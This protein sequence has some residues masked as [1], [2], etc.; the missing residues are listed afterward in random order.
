MGRSFLAGDHASL[1]Y[2]LILTIQ[3]RGNSLSLTTDGK[4]PGE[5][6]FG[7]PASKSTVELPI[8]GKIHDITPPGIM[9]GMPPSHAIVSATWEG[10]TLIV[11]ERSAGFGGI[12]SSKRRYF[13]SEDKAQLI[14]QIESH[15]T[16]GDIEQRM[17]FEKQP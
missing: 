17:V 9:P 10:G 8:D 14:A 6:V 11:T 12:T 3:L 16:F 13:L 5:G 15:N 7:L 4:N 2:V 1:E